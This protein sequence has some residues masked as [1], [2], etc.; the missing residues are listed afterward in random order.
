MQKIFKIVL[1]V[2]GVAG[3]ILAGMIWGKND[4]LQAEFEAGG[5]SNEA[6][7]AM[8]TPLLDSIT[9]LTWIVLA[10]IVVMV[11]VFVL[12][13]LFTGNAKNALIGI[14]AF[15]LVVLI[16]YFMATGVETEM[17]DGEILSAN[18]SKW[19]SAGLNA[20]FILGI[21]AIGMMA[22]SGVKKLVN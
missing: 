10:I 15:A 2:L 9:T 17:K 14:G 19:V 22:W 6:V 7:L 5:K 13:G 1:I 4:D 16:S 18:G 3:A 8:D 20:F 21:V 12:K 11:L